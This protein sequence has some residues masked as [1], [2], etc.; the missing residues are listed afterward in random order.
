MAENQTE[1]MLPC[2]AYALLQLTAELTVSIME[3]TAGG[4]VGFSIPLMEKKI[5]RGAIL[6]YLQN[7]AN[8]IFTERSKP[9][10]ASLFFF[11]YFLKLPGP[12]IV[13]DPVFLF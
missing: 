3:K 8:V 10:L 9:L 2:S 11:N 1:K 12:Y 6:V 4:A 13:R 7:A 5:R